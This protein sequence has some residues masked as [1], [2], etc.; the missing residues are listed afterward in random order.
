MRTHHA[1]LVALAVGMG[2][3]GLAVQA[4]AQA[5]T[6]G[7]GTTK[8]SAAKTSTH[9]AATRPAAAR[10]DDLLAQ[11]GLSADQ[12]K[13]VAAVRQKYESQMHPTSG[14][15]LGREAMQ[16]LRQQQDAEIG[17]I[18]TADQRTKWEQLKAAH[19]V[20]RAHTGRA[21]HAAAS[22]APKA[23]ATTGTPPAK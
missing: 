4:K 9:Q 12:Q 5:S 15:A 13:Q 16:K 21:A 11:L 14:Q 19:A 17:Q 8:G 18:L 1:V 2:C 10:G 7:Q 23:Q 20:R 6:A 3:L 22:T